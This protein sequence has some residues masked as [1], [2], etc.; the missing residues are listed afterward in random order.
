MYAAIEIANNSIDINS[1]SQTVFEAAGPALLFSL[2]IGLIH[3]SQ[4]LRS[5]FIMQH[6]VKD[7]SDPSTEVKKWVT[8]PHSIICLFLRSMSIMT[9]LSLLDLHGATLA[10][11][12]FFVIVLMLHRFHIAN[13]FRLQVAPIDPIASL[14]YDGPL[15]GSKRSFIIAFIFS[16]CE[17]GLCLGLPYVSLSFMF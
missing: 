6:F 17:T 4:T 16:T 3:S 14:L 9:L 8:I 7:T 11:F 1:S 5:M 2:T 15:A 13:V 10:A 12:I